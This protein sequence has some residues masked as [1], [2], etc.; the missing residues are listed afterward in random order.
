MQAGQDLHAI[1][2][3]FAVMIVATGFLLSADACA[4]DYTVSYAFD[5]TTR[6]DIAA[7]AMSA[8]NEEGTSKECQYETPCTIELTNLI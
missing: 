4:G 7:G 1:G 3:Y 5:G 2:V 8:L 6:G